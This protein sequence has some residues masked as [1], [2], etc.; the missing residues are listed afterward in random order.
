MV[1]MVVYTGGHQNTGLYWTYPFPITLFIFFGYR[2][3]LILNLAL[4][5]GI[6]ILVLFP[7]MTIAKYRIEEV[8][9]Y[10]ASYLVNVILCLIGEYFRYR[11]HAELTD[12]NIEKQKQA[13]T[14]SL[15]GLPN[16]RFIDSIFFESANNTPE[17]YFPMGIAALDIDYFK[18]INDNY[19]HDVGDLVLK[20]MTKSMTGVLRKSDVVAR[21]GGEEFLII[22]PGM[23][24]I[25]AQE[26]AEKVRSE[27]EQTPF[28]YKDINQEVT[29]SIGCALVEH[30]KGFDQAVKTADQRLY[31]AKT[32]GRNRVIS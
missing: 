4:L 17:Q 28:K 22:F 12:I 6:A 3:G 18:S 2:F 31:Q 20:H 10:F 11:S 15:T 27:I 16:R 9:R 13:N 32:T 14:D 30:A 21:I 29:V 8:S 23:N 24:L 25:N 7:E 19:G 26:I 1:L 5:T